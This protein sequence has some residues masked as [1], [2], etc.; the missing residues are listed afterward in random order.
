MASTKKTV[1]I[2][3]STRGIGLAFVEH[4][5]K[6]GWNVI[7]TARANS[8]REKLT[9]LSPFKIVIVDTADEPSIVEA[10]RQLEGESLM[11]QFEVNAAGPFLVTRTLLPNL[12]LAA[13]VHGV[14]IVVQLSSLLGSIS[15]CTPET[16]ALYKDAIYGYGSSKA[17]LNMITRSLAVELRDSNIAVVS[18]HP[19][20]VDTDMTQ[21]KATLKPSDSVAAMTSLIAQLT[22]DS[23]SKFFNL[24]SQIPVSELPW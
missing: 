23:T 8:N 6:A 18:L 11:R 21:G 19:G 4:Y 1:L 16:A 7:A 12:Q 10:A 17:A 20:Y 22:L 9:A 14:A 24:D 15:N 2:T 5:V 3:G 13:K